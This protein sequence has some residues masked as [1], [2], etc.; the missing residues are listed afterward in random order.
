MPKNKIVDVGG[1][2]YRVRG[3]TFEEL[4]RLGSAGAE[5]KGSKAV[6]AEVLSR[7]LLEPRL[8]SEQIIRLP[9]KT[10]VVLVTEVLDIAKSSLEGMGFVSMPS[11][12]GP[13]RDM[14]A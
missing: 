4:V 9:D 12:K 1:T 6:V 13:P 10:L 7:C 5:E 3:L 14:I 11:D 8:E 2:R